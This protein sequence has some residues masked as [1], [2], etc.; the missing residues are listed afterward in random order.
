MGN[1]T[2]LLLRLEAP[3]QSYGER[4]KWDFR[5]SA[6]FPTKSGVIGIIACAMGLKRG[7]DEIRGIGRAHV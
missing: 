5:D 4:A 7:A 3:L 6:Y 1:Q 2:I